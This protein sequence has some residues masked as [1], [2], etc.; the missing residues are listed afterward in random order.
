MYGHVQF[1]I[2]N[3]NFLQ[4]S[5]KLLTKSYATF[6]RKK[7]IATLIWHQ[8]TSL[9]VRRIFPVLFLFFRL[10]FRCDEEVTAIVFRLVCPATSLQHSLDSV[11]FYIEISSGCYMYKKKLTRFCILYYIM[12]RFYI[13]STI[14]Q[15]IVV[16]GNFSHTND[17]RSLIGCGVC[18][19][20]RP[21]Q[22]G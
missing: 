14:V 4:N 5:E 19:A 11:Y 7:L 21:P 2:I 22:G 18:C 1:E 8:L 16:F 20:L 13:I 15:S 3:F 6:I 9:F 17:L 10:L 12:R